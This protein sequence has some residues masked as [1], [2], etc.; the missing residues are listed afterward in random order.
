MIGSGLTNIRDGLTGDLWR[1]VFDFFRLTITEL[2]FDDASDVLPDDI[3]DIWSSYFVKTFAS[4]ID[5]LDAY[6]GISGDSV[7]TGVPGLSGVGNLIF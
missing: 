4:N 1:L 5:H 2:S 6:L 3:I 7:D